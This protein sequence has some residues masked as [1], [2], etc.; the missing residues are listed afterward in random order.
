MP[1]KEISCHVW[2]AE[3]VLAALQKYELYET[4]KTC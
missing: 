3:E 4:L 2:I 1:V